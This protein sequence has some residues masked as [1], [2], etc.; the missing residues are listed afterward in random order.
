MSHAPAAHLG[1][2]TLSDDER[3]MY[4]G[5]I[6][7]LILAEAM[8][9]AS[10]FSTRFL[11][12][13]MKTPLHA[14]NTIGVV[15]TAALIL[16]VIPASV[17]LRRIGSGDNVG[18]ARQLWLV[19][20]L[21]AV[22]LAAILFDWTNLAFLAG[23]V[24]GENYVLSTGYHALHILIGVVWLAAAAVAGRRGVY[25]QGNHWVVEGGVLFWYFVV[26]M[27]IAL[28]LIFFVV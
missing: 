27:W 19:A 17:A 22:A 28:Y 16:S 2:R 9:F 24:F 21:G 1:A 14:G 18:M 20:L 7:L 12:D 5:G 3:R 6:W 15:I 23:S 11:L 13:G 25:T 8:A 4:R 10:V 26:A